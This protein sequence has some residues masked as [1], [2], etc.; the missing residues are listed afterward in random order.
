MQL[1][2]H[3]CTVSH[4]N[5]VL[6]WLRRAIAPS[7]GCAGVALVSCRSAITEKAALPKDSASAAV[8]RTQCVGPGYDCKA[9]AE[10][11][12]EPISSGWVRIWTWSGSAP[13]AETESG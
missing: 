2:R 4:V 7:W 13:K 10:V 3:R 1:Q 9:A 8:A 5:S 11:M 12:R 6:K